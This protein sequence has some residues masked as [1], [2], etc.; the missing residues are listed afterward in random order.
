MNNY[1]L[2]PL[3][4]FMAVLTLSGCRS[5][6]SKDTADH[7]TMEQEELTDTTPPGQEI[8]GDD[9]VSDHS[10]SL[11]EDLTHAKDDVETD[12]KTGLDD[13]EDHLDDGIGIPFDDMLDNAYVHDTDGIL[14][15]GENAQ[16][17]DFL[18]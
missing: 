2:V 7:N 13:V 5:D 10:D 11:Q 9:V 3:A 4:T 12:L 6:T 1:T 18:K 16:H 17:D 8:L 14:T 15:D